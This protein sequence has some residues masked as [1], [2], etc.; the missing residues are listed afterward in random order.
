MAE[1]SSVRTLAGDRSGINLCGNQLC[2]NDGP[3]F[4]ATAVVVGN[5]RQFVAAGLKR[6]HWKTAAP[7]RTVFSQ[8]FAQAGLPYFNPHSPRNTLVQLGER[9]CRTP[10]QFKAWSQNLGHEKVLTTFCS[11][12]EVSRPR[13]GELI[14]GLLDSARPDPAVIEIAKAVA[15]E[16]KGREDV[17]AP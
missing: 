12:G 11:Y 16:L 10:E 14:R 1:C 17:V 15:R 3:L 5:K 9:R 6:E 2:G 8:A 7:I 4:P 13:Q